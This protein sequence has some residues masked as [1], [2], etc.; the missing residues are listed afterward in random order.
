MARASRLL[1]DVIRKIHIH[2][3]W[4]DGEVFYDKKI[5]AMLDAGA[6]IIVDTA[7]LRCK[8][9]TACLS[10]TD[11]AGS[12]KPTNGDSQQGKLTST[13]HEQL[14]IDAPDAWI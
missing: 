9:G 3:Q 7:D 1:I 2:H 4:E 10:Q 8:C 11:A 14:A 12:V 13:R 6:L 5:D